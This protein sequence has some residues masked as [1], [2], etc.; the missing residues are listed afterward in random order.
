MSEAFAMGSSPRDGGVPYEIQNNFR[1]LNAALEGYYRD[2]G[3]FPP[4][5]IY[6]ANGKALLSWRVLL[7]PYLEGTYTDESDHHSGPV[8]ITKEG[9][10]PPRK[11]YA[12]LF[13][14]FKLDEPW[15]SLHNKKLLSKM[16]SV[17]RR[18]HY[19]YSYRD[20]GAMKTGTMM[21]DGPGAILNGQKR[22]TKESIKDGLSN[23]VH[24]VVTGN[25]DRM[26]Y[27]TKPIDIPFAADK[28]LPTLTRKYEQG[29]YALLADGSHVS[30][31]NAFVE[32]SLKSAVT[33]EGGETF[34]MPKSTI[35]PY[36]KDVV[37]YIEKK[38]PPK[39]DKDPI[40]FDPTSKDEPKK[41]FD[42]KEVKK[43]PPK[44][45]EKP[46]DDK[47]EFDS[48]EARKDPPKDPPK[49]DE[50]PKEEPKKAEF[51]KKFSA[52]VESRRFE[53]VSFAPEILLLEPR[54]TEVLTVMPRI[55]PKG[56][57]SMSSPNGGGTIRSS[58]TY[59][60]PLDLGERAARPD[61]PLDVLKFNLDPFKL[62]GRSN[63]FD[64]IF[65]LDHRWNLDT[66]RRE[67]LT[68]MPREKK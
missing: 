15:D 27:W 44:I 34:D 12:E 16:P 31:P 17:Y 22:L 47:K 63:L 33:I 13:K 41:A 59:Y 24:V 4:A 56:A 6:D 26:A 39:F 35:D 67:I 57:V 51:D 11:T 37:P 1:Q 28:P 64:P 23:T 50:K 20:G 58:G 19:Y 7:L 46:G 5:A 38:D 14:Q 60:D 53:F 68:V 10:G 66:L 25:D 9:S 32:K 18:T 62:G 45:D 61:N 52:A 36:R 49:V 29:I 2:K 54:E 48:K 40:K 3:C 43:D 30:L 55:A 8:T 65:D 42:P 21:F